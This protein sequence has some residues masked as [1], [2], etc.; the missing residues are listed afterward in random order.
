MLRNP[1]LATVWTLLLA[2][3]PPHT[4]S[5][6]QPTPLRVMTYNLRY[7]STKQP[8]SWSA[9]RPVARELVRKEAPDVIGTQEGLYAQLKDLSDDLPR[10]DWIGLGREGGSRGEFMAV[11]FRRER[12]EPIAFD[13]F[14]LS[15]TPEVVGSATWG[16]TNRRMVTWV[17]FLDRRSGRRFYLINTHFDHRV[18][19][20]RERSAGL[21]L[22]RMKA[23][24]TRDPVIV[25]GDFNAAAGDSTAY[26][27]LTASGPLRDAW[28]E[29]ETKGP[30][31]STFHGYRTPHP[32]GRRIDWILYHGS[33]IC[34]STRVIT[35]AVDGQYP[36]DHFPVLAELELGSDA[37]PVS[38]R[39]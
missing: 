27:L 23:L 11:F 10:Y 25:T 20:A 36:S 12:L 15:D 4:A 17:H 16:H 34:R 32:D 5:G 38:E 39:K 8:N 13:H 24:E 18:P 1:T 31:L 28:L 9:R 14:W 7:A 3:L 2:S 33:V 30:A 37:I 26:S 19:L 21:L 35:F 6:Q 22:E 29:A